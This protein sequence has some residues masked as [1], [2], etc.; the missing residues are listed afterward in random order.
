[1]KIY[2]IEVEQKQ[3][4]NLLEL[5]AD[6][7]FFGRSFYPQE[8]KKQAFNIV[9]LQE[10]L[11]DHV[12]DLSH[13]TLPKKLFSGDASKVPSIVNVSYGAFFDK[14]PFGN[15]TLK[16]GFETMAPL[17][18]SAYIEIALEDNTTSL[19]AKKWALKHIVGAGEYI[20]SYDFVRAINNEE[21]EQMRIKY[22]FGN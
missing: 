5:V 16:F 8:R 10:E 21:S 20:I 11:L 13:E 15:E 19:D 12:C 17:V 14:T 7:G 1:M 9:E 18:F 4:V 6:S 3:D 22:I 2:W